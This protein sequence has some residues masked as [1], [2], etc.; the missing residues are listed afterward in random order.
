MFKLNGRVITRCES[1][2]YNLEATSSEDKPTV[3]VHYGLGHLFPWRRGVL[4]IQRAVLHVWRTYTRQEPFWVLVR[5]LI[6]PQGN[7]LKKTITW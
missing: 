3:G 5:L 6:T 1:Y 4:Y 2:R 7:P